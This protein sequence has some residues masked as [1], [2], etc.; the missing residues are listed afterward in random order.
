MPSPTLSSLFALNNTNID[1]QIK[2][3]SAGVYALDATSDPTFTYSYVGRSDDDVGGRLKKWV[4]KKYKYAKF[5]YCSSRKDAFEA[6]CNLYHD[7]GPPDNTNHPARPEGSSWGCPR[8]QI[9]D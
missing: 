2:R 6:E 7:H 3:E 9:F 8:C 5:A 4:G 1:E